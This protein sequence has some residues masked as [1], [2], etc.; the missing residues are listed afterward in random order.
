MS[1]IICTSKLGAWAISFS[2]SV[3]LL[4]KCFFA[5]TLRPITIFDTPESLANSAICKGISSPYTVSI[6]APNC[7]ARCTLSRS[8]FLSSAFIAEKAGVSTNNAVKSLRKAFAILA[9]V[10]INFALEGEEE[11]HTRIC[12]SV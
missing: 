7:L 9:A 12:S 4:N 2:V 10:R 11:R 6:F 3:G 1:G 5:A 8:L